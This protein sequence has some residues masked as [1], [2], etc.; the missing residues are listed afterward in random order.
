MTPY[1]LYGLFHVKNFLHLSD[2]QV[3]VWCNYAVGERLA[4]LVNW[5]PFAIIL[6]TNIFLTRY[7]ILYVLT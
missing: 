6:P 3:T 2:M 7:Y 5:P 1:V 4:N